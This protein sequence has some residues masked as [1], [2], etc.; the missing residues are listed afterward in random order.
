MTRPRSATHGLFTATINDVA[1]RAGVSKRTVSR[2][3]NEEPNITADTRDRVLKVI[4][5]LGY[6]PNP[7]A[8][9][10]ASGKSHLIGL[11]HSVCTPPDAALVEQITFAMASERYRV[12]ICSSDH[13][14][15]NAAEELASLARIVPIDG[16]ILC[17][18]L[19]E[20]LTFAPAF[21][22]QKIPCVRIG[23]SAGLHCVSSDDREAAR[24]MTRY[25]ASLGHQRIGFVCG[26]R[27][28][29]SM[30]QRR[31]GFFDG[32]Q[33]AG[34]PIDPCIILQGVDT[35]DSGVECGRRL[36][37]DTAG[38]P[39]AIFA[40]TDA[41]ATGILRAAHEFGIPVPKA[42]SVAG[43]GDQPVASQLWPALTTVRPPIRAL[44]DR[45]AA[46]LLE[47]LCRVSADRSQSLVPSAEIILRDS[48]GPLGAQRVQLSIR[49]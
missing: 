39:T 25:L 28:H 13:R 48:T 30:Q 37:S 49:N 46:A 16:A 33:I 18:P 5:R 43:F 31:Q 44:A 24:Q 15:P 4:E 38:R 21:H 8:R 10:L 7:A 17:A 23:T 34:L 26:P 20:Q 32:L 47:L 40:S 11:F 6:R 3:M 42:L 1:A 35:F 14:S 29:D 36:L 45:A 27:E 2:V 41:M 12:L 22:A 19:S 9:R